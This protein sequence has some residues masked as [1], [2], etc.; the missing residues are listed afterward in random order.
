[1]SNVAGSQKRPIGHTGSVNSQNTKPYDKHSKYEG[2][3]TP[4]VSI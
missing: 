2:V 1:M 3:K 4:K